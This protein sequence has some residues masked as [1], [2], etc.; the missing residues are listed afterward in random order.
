MDGVAIGKSSVALTVRLI[1]VLVVLQILYHDS[2]NLRRLLVDLLLQFLKLLVFL[3]YIILL[4]NVC[5]DH[6]QSFF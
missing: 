1:Y 4:D 6:R 2:R 5:H 3:F